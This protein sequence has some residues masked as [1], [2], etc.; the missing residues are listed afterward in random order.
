MSV[1]GFFLWIWLAEQLIR[2]VRGDAIFTDFND[3]TGLIFNGNAA[4]TNCDYDIY[5]AYGATQGNDDV[6]NVGN[7]S[8]EY[9]ENS[10]LV[11]EVNIQTNLASDDV[12]INENLAVGVHRNDTLPSPLNCTERIRLTSSAPSNAGSIW[13]RE[14]ISVSDG[15]DTYFTFQITDHSKVIYKALF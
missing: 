12:D 14:P 7:F 8:I 9:S 15:F 4:T 6:F 5:H 3:T 13:Y 11:S 2:N 1:L 10:D